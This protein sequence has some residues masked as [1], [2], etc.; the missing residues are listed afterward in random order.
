M[1]KN[2]IKLQEL[3]E[4]KKRSKYF[5][6][7]SNELEHMEQYLH[8]A[9]N[10]L[11]LEYVPIKIVSCFESYFR[12]IYKEIIDNPTYRTRLK[13]IRTLKDVSYDFD[14]LGAFEDNVITLGD[15]L[16]HLIP[17]SKLE[18]INAT[19]SDLL[20]IHFL[21]R[22]KD[23]L[24][25]HSKLLQSIIEIFE[26]RH[27]YCH[28]A[29]KVN[30]IDYEKSMTS[31]HDACDFL[32]ISDKIVHTILYPDLPVTSADM[33]DYAEKSFKQTEHLLNELIEEIKSH[34]IED[35]D[36]EFLEDWKKY[37]IA[38]AKSDSSFVQDGSMYLVFYY[39]SLERTTHFFMK[40]LMDEFGRR[41]GL[42]LS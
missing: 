17:C 26:L 30:R 36:L 24:P 37:R 3:L 18:D 31:I 41:L 35:L 27:I 10:S 23:E 29:P 12:G 34:D 21:E 42:S 20:N 4:T 15:Y 19:L 11:L 1:R 8:E 6:L 22:I 14:V 28:E 25:C 38:K 32:T 7:V 9:K 13:E 33:V 39:Q 16:S 5:E 40:Q 2:R